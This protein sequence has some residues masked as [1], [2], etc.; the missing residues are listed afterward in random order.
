MYQLSP[1]NISIWI[2]IFEIWNFTRS[3]IKTEMPVRNNHHSGTHIHIIFY[4][5]HIIVV[6][7]FFYCQ[8]IYFKSASFCALILKMRIF[9]NRPDHEIKENIKHKYKAIYYW[10]I[11]HFSEFCEKL[12]NIFPVVINEPKLV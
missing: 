10:T 5:F 12:N 11:S 7:I 3:Q 8:Y 4:D 9:I 6:I 1:L 2:S